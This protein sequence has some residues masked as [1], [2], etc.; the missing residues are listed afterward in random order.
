MNRRRFLQS[1]T[2]AAAAVAM[3]ARPARAAAKD[4]TNIVY[5]LADDLGYGDLSCYGQK[6]FTTPNIDR[7]AAEGMRFTQHYSGST[8]C[9]P[10][11]CA[12]MTGLHT[13]HC[14]VRGNR[15]HKPIGQEPIPAETVTVAKLLRKAGYAT[16]MFGKW[17]LGPPGSV[18]D[19]MKQGFDEFYGYNCQRNAHTYYPKRLYHNDKAIALDGKTYSHDLIAEKALGF[20]RANK[21]RPFFC[22]MPVTI[23]HASMHVPEKYVAPFRKKFPQFE[24]KIG[25]YSGPNVKNPVAAFAGMM[26]KL[27]EDVG[28]VVALLK[29]L[30]IDRK[31]LV[32]FTSDNGP[33]G[34]GGHQPGFFDSN[35]PLTGMKR[36]LTEGGIRV[37]MIARWTGQIP[38]GTESDHISAFWDVLP[39]ACE[40]AG[41]EPPKK[42]DG[43]SFVPALLGRKADQKRHEYLYW[44]YFYGGGIRAVRMGKWK[45]L[46]RGLH[47]RAD[48]PILLYDLEADLAEKKNVAAEQPQ[49]VERMRKIFAEARTPSAIWRFP[50]IDGKR[51]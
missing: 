7:M 22:Y 34:E 44:E 30:G 10:S 39:T 23:P 36:T 4:K 6:K 42:I 3:R 18:G 8:V 19:P 2:A 14:H 15:E 51:S 28:R 27:D 17:G 11:R 32:I 43:I 45:A 41:I 50:Q 1:A 21:E 5:I 9:A 40:L 20:I 13:G 38:P 37:P 49:I 16:G 48:A 35:G 24:D 25:R 26:T 33:H 29:E 31:T 46:Q 47:K 12:L